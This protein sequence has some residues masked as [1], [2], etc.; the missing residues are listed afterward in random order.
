MEIK[1]FIFNPFQEN[2]YLLSNDEKECIVIDPGA[3]FE[4]ERTQLVNY[5]KENGLQLKRVL[6]THLHLDHIF[7][8]KTLFDEFG[9]SPEAHA[10]DEFL[11]ERFPEQMRQ[12]GMM[13]EEK[14]VPLKGYLKEGMVI[15]FGKSELHVIH[16]PGHSPGGLCFYAPQE[17]IVFCGDS[18]FQGS[19]GRTDLEG[20]NGSSLIQSIQQKILT[21]PGNTEV[22]S[23]HGP[24]STIEFELRYNP[25]FHEG[26]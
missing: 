11:L 14:C 19:I 12:F 23:G 6:Q 20:G 24:K 25:F 18:L 7:G 17:N 10:A 9:V 1:Q 3:L 13:G 15:P 8:C 26:Y 21:L 16:T 22:R 2:T 4:M 5:I